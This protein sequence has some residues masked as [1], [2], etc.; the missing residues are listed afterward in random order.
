M[1][2]LQLIEI[3]EEDIEV[4]SPIMKRAF[5]RDAMMHIGKKGWT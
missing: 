3:G 5:D 1:E 4:L 2:R